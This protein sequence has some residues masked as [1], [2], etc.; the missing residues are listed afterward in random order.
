M[1]PLWKA[2]C[3]IQHDKD[4]QIEAAYYVGLGDNIKWYVASKHNILSAYD[5]RLANLDITTIH[6]MSRN[7]QQQWVKQLDITREAYALELRQRGH[8][9]NL[10]TR[11]MV[12][13]R[14]IVH[15]T[16]ESDY[17]DGINN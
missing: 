13:L 9:Q 11:Y 5:S 1:V 4:N 14:E 3:K 16:M 8:N 10:I 15:N 2:R 6:R 17:R 12:L 7:Q